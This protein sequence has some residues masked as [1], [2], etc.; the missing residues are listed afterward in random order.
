LRTTDDIIRM[1]QPGTAKQ[2]RLLL[3]FRQLTNDHPELF[4][5]LA[6]LV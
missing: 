6:G 4:E 3:D 1:A 2:A 5:Q